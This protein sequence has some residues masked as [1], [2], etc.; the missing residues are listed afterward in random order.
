MLTSFWRRVRSFCCFFKQRTEIAIKE[1]FGTALT[2]KPITKQAASHY[3]E[4]DPV[5]DHGALNLTTDNVALI[6]HLA[7]IM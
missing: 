4:V 2:L 5:P 3:L 6:W 1:K 7:R